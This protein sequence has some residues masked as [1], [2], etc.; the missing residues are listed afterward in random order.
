MVLVSLTVSCLAIVA[1]GSG[2]GRTSSPTA[3]SLTAT[4]STNPTSVTTLADPQVQS[5]LQRALLVGTDL[6]G[7]WRVSAAAASGTNF[8]ASLC[9][10]HLDDAG[11][12]GREQ[13][14]LETS[15][16]A[17]FESVGLYTSDRAQAMFAAAHTL[18]E[19]CMDWTRTRSG[20][21]VSLHA[22]PLSLP[23]LG[24]SA[25]AVAITA[26]TSDQ[27]TVLREDFVIIQRGPVVITLGHLGQNSLT[28]TEDLAMRAAAK[29]ESAGAPPE[30][31]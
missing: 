24:E 29:L 28:G 5:F 3:P 4:A 17:L 8:D 26:T 12:L 19:H 13:A 31:R 25:L 10:G 9:G 15:T 11:Y 27:Q 20:L 2:K 14:T 22:V 1:C 21:T 16:E 18:V 7:T 30:S 6:P 23:S